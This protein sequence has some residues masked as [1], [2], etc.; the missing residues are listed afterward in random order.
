[1]KIRFKKIEIVNKSSCP[2]GSFRR[3]FAVITLNHRLNSVSFIPNFFTRY[4]Y[5]N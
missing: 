3:A 1:M 4:V 5:Q 2:N